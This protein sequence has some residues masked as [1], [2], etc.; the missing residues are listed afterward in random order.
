MSDT[1]SW[2]ALVLGGSRKSSDP[3][4]DAAGVS[5]KAFARVGGM[6]MIERVVA[7]LRDSECI[8]GITV[9]LPG[10]AP[11]DA[12]SP[13]LAVA[14]RDGA[15]VRV[16]PAESPSASALEALRAVPPDTGLLI[17]TADHALLTPAMVR[18]FCNGAEEADAHAAIGLARWDAVQRAYPGA[19]RTCLTFR[20]G[21]YSN[22]NLFAFV[23]P[24][25]RCAVAFWQGLEAYRKSPARLAARIGVGSMLGY[26]SRRWTAAE[27]MQRLGRRIGV[28]TAPVVLEH[29]EAAI[30]VDTSADL[31]LATAIATNADR[32]D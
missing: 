20:D 10:T 9:C 23:G 31:E 7:A 15:V 22:C 32:C 30:D 16:E 13:G 3:V 8:D 19:I 11:I 29:P 28:R 6:P 1:R 14:L 21:G 4:A 25:A 17:T 18:D 2:H 12:E 27:A 24:E 5:I 26:L